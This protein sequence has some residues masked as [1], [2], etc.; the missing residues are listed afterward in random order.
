MKNTPVIVALSLGLLPLRAQTQSLSLQFTQ[1]APRS[2]TVTGSEYTAAKSDGI[3][4]RY[5]HELG[6]YSALGEARLVFEGS[7]L[8]RTG[9]KDLK[10]DGQIVAGP[11]ASFRY[12][13]EYMGLGLALNWTKLVDLGA[14]L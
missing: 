13:Q 6:V 14:A 4:L 7:W 10:R 2:F 12:R 3:A 1:L 8:P 11:G 5:G 9:G